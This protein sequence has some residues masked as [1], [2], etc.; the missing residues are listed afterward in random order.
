V[1]G[2]IENIEIANVWT[3]FSSFLDNDVASLSP[4]EVWGAEVGCKGRL[5]VLA[6]H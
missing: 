1:V 2:Q 5:L 6:V 3:A 4:R